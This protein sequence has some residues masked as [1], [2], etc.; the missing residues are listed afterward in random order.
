MDYNSIESLQDE[1]FKG[2]VAIQ[3]MMQNTCMNVPFIQG[4][5]FVLNTTYEK[6]FLAESTGGWFKKKDPS[7]KQ[8]DL[9]RNWV[10]NTI[11]LNMGKAGGRD[12]NATLNSRLKQYMRFGQ[13]K[14]V[15]H[16]GGR[17]IWQLSNSSELL[18]CWKELPDDEPRE[19]E[20]EYIQDFFRV[21]GKRPFANL[22]G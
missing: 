5:Y 19:I 17:L 7:V 4:V 16:W 3:S 1:G 21:F 10:D 11:V 9:E 8:S 15:G 22:T 20:R 18:I 13:G 14:P 2:F 12:S 6:T